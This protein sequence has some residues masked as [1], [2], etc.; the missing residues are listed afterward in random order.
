MLNRNL[1]VASLLVLLQATSLTLAN[2][3]L[4]G[5]YTRKELVSQQNPT[6]ARVRDLRDAQVQQIRT[7]LGRRNPS[8]RRADLYLRLAEL[9][10]EAYRADFIL[11]GRVHEKN[12]E[13]AKA[14]PKTLQRDFSKS[15]LRA[16]IDACSRIL[17]LNLRYEKMDQVLYFLGYAYS[18]LDEK[19][20]AETYFHKL[21]K[22]YP[23]SPMAQDAYREIGE[24]A[25]EDRRWHDA[26]DAFESS[27]KSDRKR[28][29][30]ARVLHRM[31]WSHYRLKQYDRAVATMKESVQVASTY[32]ESLLSIRDEALRDMAIF[33]TE[34]GRVEEAISYFQ[35]VSGDRSFYPAT[36]EKLGRQYERNVEM[37]KAIQ[38]YESLLKTNPEDEATLRVRAKLVELDLRNN[39]PA[40]AAGR[41]RDARLDSR[42]FKDK[43]SQETRAALQN[44][45]AQIRRT[46]TESH[47]RYRKKGNVQDLA[48]AEIFYETYLNPLLE[49][50]DPRREIPEIRMYLAEIKREQG[51]VKEASEL[52]RKVI[53]SEDPR[54]SK[55]AGALWTASLADAIRRDSKSVPAG[56]GSRLDPSPMELEFVEAADAMQDNLG[57]TQEGREAA[58]KAAQVLGGYTNTKRDAKKRAARMV[59]K[60]PRS[61]QG[62]TAARLWLQLVSDELPTDLAKIEDSKAASELQDVMGDLRKNKDLMAEDKSKGGKLADS[63]AQL[64]S[65]LKAGSIAERERS[66]EYDDAARGYEEFAR[67]SKDGSTAEKAWASAFD[68]WV[69]AKSLVDSD[70]VLTEW[71]RRHPKSVKPLDAGRFLATQ[72]L[73]DGDLKRTI[74]GFER[75][76][77]LDA[78]GAAE[79]WN[80][81][82]RVAEASGESA[83][84]ITLWERVL[85]S[86]T[87][88]LS[89]KATVALSL[90]QLHAREGREPEAAQA[91]RRGMGDTSSTTVE[92]LECRLALGNLYQRSRD[93]PKARSEFEALAALKGIGPY[94]A[95]A[96]FAIA[97]MD[98]DQLGAPPALQLPEDALKK[99]VQARLGYLEKM[100]KLLGPVISAGGSHGISALHLLSLAAWK[101]ADDLEH[102]EFPKDWVAERKKA[103][104]AGIPAVAK[105]LR[106]QALEQWKT[107]WDRAQK[108][109]LFASD[110]PAISDRLAH[111][112]VASVFR[113]Q[114]TRL[115]WRLAGLSPDGGEDGN[116]TALSKVRQKLTGSPKNAGLW[117][118]YG[119]LLWGEGR[120]GLARLAYDRALG[121]NS[122]SASALTNRGVLELQN[123]A[124]A[125]EDPILALRASEY[126]RRAVSAE[127]FHLPSR[128]NLGSLMNLY[129]LFGGA[130]P[131]LEQVV[132]KATSPDAW[133]FL[134]VSQ[135]GLGQ[136]A[137]SEASFVKAD[138]LGGLP[139]RFV[140]LYH[141]AV[142]EAGCDG[143]RSIL[144]EFKIAELQGFEKEAVLRLTEECIK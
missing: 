72:A 15:S 98:L 67:A 136:M 36:L 78:S 130:R 10:L 91:F 84:A 71:A 40:V 30:A 1:A 131:F 62:Q 118:D 140:R 51:K 65:R 79:A 7:T 120:L 44:L 64:E 88:P 35:S 119:N 19:S 29:S 95:A 114:G 38:V 3:A 86:S 73:I 70:R 122:N 129:R 45:R 116:Q 20:R 144:G 132:T 81:A 139:T 34:T 104:E 105:P 75:V 103:L 47:E 5:S 92:A 93:L 80:T 57:S 89:L 76:A 43:G 56:N 123:V 55:E 83:R 138:S 42:V 94:R 50:W 11:E 106:S 77:S 16:A 125:P 74:D 115:R 21:A 54:Y 85:N 31:A 110:L 48:T 108:D 100:G 26:L 2:P 87:A 111:A 63:I 32:G 18:E 6:E 127:D 37:V 8:N 14:A 133:D 109:Q 53:D 121:L 24:T 9:Y 142:R 33:M 134:A 4:A 61:S 66:H 107:A 23:R 27:L 99:S 58:L 68:N 128:L 97:R 46:A 17:E 135:A 124:S 102:L 69:R 52:Y 13:S 112:G 12:L 22:E 82:A 25:F 141:R 96:L 126:F 59:E 143:K 41:V 113:A 60:N 49:A 90:G 117:V 28:E 137:D 101:S 39:K